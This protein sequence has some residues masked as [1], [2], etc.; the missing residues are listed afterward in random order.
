SCCWCECALCALESD[1]RR[2]RWV[3]GG[4][5]AAGGA[6]KVETTVVFARRSRLVSWFVGGLNFQ[7]EHHLFPRVCHIHYPAIAH[8]VEETCQAF[9][10]RYT[11]HASLLAALASHYRWLRRMGTATAV[12]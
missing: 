7:I 3:L 10:L 2:R 12:G 11:A 4:R 5:P 1:S 9:G 6:H 8:L